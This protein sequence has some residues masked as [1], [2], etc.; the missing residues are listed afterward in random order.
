MAPIVQCPDS[1]A[2]A[3]HIFTFKL[4]PQFMHRDTHR[5]GVSVKEGVVSKI[6]DVMPGNDSKILANP[7]TWQDFRAGHLRKYV[8]TTAS[9]IPGI[10]ETAPT[11][12]LRDDNHSVFI[13]R[14][15]SCTVLHARFVILLALVRGFTTVDG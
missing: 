6:M 13:K 7:G 5:V 9:A 8:M 2:A 14:L 1:P 11:A 12:G 10:H 3:L 4:Q 15:M